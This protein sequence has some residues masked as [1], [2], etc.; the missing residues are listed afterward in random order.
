MINT[1]KKDSKKVVNLKASLISKATLEV[2]VG[3]E[4]WAVAAV[5]ASRLLMRMKY[6]KMHSEAKIHSKASSVMTTI[7]SEVASEAWE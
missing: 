2:L 3:S 5:V 6:S 1:G 7:S 4:E